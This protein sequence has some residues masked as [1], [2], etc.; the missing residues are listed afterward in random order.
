VQRSSVLY[1]HLA[2]SLK[3]LA[4]LKINVTQTLSTTAV[5]VLCLWRGTYTG[6]REQ[7]L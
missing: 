2:K 3:L 6:P 4:V 7:A 1:M 5:A